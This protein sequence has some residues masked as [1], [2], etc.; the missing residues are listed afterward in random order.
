MTA[1]EAASL[2]V[3]KPAAFY[4]FFAPSKSPAHCLSSGLHGGGRKPRRLQALT[5]ECLAV[6]PLHGA[7]CGGAIAR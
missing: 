7:T 6:R 4:F 1:A 3:G 5:V 2:F